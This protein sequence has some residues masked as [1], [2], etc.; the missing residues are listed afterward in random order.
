MS[1]GQ[2]ARD[3]GV[4]EMTIRR[5]LRTLEEEGLVVPCYGG[6]LAARRLTL[7]FAFDERRRSQQA[8]KQRIGEAAAELVEEGQSILLDTGTT[9][10][11]VAKSLA[12]RSLSASVYTTSLVIA[13]ELWGKPNLTLYLLGGQVRPGSPD[14]AGPVAEIMLERLAVDIAFLGSDGI[15]VRRGSFAADIETARLSERMIACA[16]SHVI[17]ADGTKLGRPGAVRYAAV[18]DMQALIT[19]RSAPKPMLRALKAKD[20][21]VTLA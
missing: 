19:D 16:A 9:T 3:F 4:S 8:E 15:D 20:V 10:L 2:L 12:K 6:A 5:D 18:K 14:L 7:E 1:T 13:S 11:E 21:D 17:V